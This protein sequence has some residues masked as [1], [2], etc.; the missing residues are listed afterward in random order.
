MA[1]S[2]TVRDYDGREYPVSPGSAIYALPGIAGSHEWELGKDGLQP[3]SI[4]ATLKG[5]KRMQFTVDRKSQQS[6]I[7]LDELG[8]TDAVSFESHN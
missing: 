4:R 5:H 1:G 8:R 2:A 6:Y 3:L 7:E